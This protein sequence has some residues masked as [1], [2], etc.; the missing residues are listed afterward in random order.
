M[1]KKK[2]KPDS[3]YSYF[4]NGVVARDNEPPEIILKRFKREVI[5][6]G[7]ISEIKKREFFEKPSAIRKRLKE[8]ASRKRNRRKSDFHY[9]A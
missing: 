9:G 1:D 5:N 7:V 2:D 8:A 3:I 4:Y 6:K